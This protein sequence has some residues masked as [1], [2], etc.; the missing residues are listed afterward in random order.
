MSSLKQV[1]GDKIII[2]FIAQNMYKHKEDK[3]PNALLQGQVMVYPVQAESQVTKLYPIL[4]CLVLKAT[5]FQ[6]EGNWKTIYLASSSV[7]KIKEGS[8]LR[9]Y[10]RR[11]ECGKKCKQIYLYFYVK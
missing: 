10:F 9:T 2:R 7:E 11:I 6:V 1:G 4:T 8:P 3:P 5:F